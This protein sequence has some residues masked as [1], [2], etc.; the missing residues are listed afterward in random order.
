MLKLEYTP[1]RVKA[2]LFEKLTFH[3]P[4]TRSIT[5]TKEKERK[6][7]KTKLSDD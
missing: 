3:I 5:S 4:Q 7:K 6:E 1:R 2:K